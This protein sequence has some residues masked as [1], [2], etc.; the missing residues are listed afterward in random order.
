VTTVATAQIK[1]LPGPTTL[2]AL[3]RL[4]EVDREP[5]L[6]QRDAIMVWLADNT[7]NPALLLSL[8]ANNYGLLLQLRSSRRSA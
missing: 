5:V 1:G 3:L 4:L 7:P 6:R 2:P 8:L